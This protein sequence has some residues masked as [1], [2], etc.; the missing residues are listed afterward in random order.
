MRIERLDPA[1]AAAAGQVFTASHSN[2]P[3]FAFMFPDPEA[4]ARALRPFMVATAHDA[5]LHGHP[6]AAV[7]DD[8]VLGVALWMG[9]GE[10]PL[11]TSRK[12]RMTPALLRVGWAAPRC[13]GRFI[14]VGASLERAFPSEPCWYLQ[15]M[16][17]HPRSQRRGVGTQL[18]EPVLRRADEDRMPCY[19]QTS[20]PANV[21]YYERFGFAVTQ[22]AIVTVPDGHLYI[23]MHRSAAAPRP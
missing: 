7:D 4:R 9:P 5:A 18:I 16:G 19:L 8:G 17:V 6:L 14:R 13:F 1:W 22:P 2:Y 15:A 23:G 10:F 12:A 3:G 20:D 11:T 21:A